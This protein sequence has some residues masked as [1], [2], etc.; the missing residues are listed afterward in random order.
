MRVTRDAEGAAGDAAAVERNGGATIETDGTAERL[1]ALC[2]DQDLL[3]VCGSADGRSVEGLVNTIAL[4]HGIPWLLVRTFGAEG[5]VGPLFTP[6]DGPCHA[7][8]LAREEA[9][10]AD[11]ALTAAYV[12]RL[13]HDTASVA[14]YGRS[15]ALDALVTAW[16][17]LEVTKWVSRFT[18]PG[19]LGALL[20]IDPVVASTQLH[21]ILR[22]PR[23][24]SCST[25]VHRPTVDTLLYG[26]GR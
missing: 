6:G 13:V 3:V 21:R 24:G 8:L 11:R 14:A 25:V 20:R 10:W 18:V 5:R 16:T 17:V 12:E 23:C 9:N 4:D 1:V 2:R 26:R 19:V 22:V 15:P 7:C